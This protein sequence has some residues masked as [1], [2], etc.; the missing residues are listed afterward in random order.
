MSRK[1]K[2]D[3]DEENVQDTKAEALKYVSKKAKNEDEKIEGE[4]GDLWRYT[5]DNTIVVFKL[6]FKLWLKLQV[7]LLI[8]ADDVVRRAID[9]VGVV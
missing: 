1:R 3:E 2:S 8:V 9:D 6:R 7:Q 4:M 5:I